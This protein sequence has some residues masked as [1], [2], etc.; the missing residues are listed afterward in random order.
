MAAIGE[1]RRASLDLA[2]TASSSQRSGASAV[3]TNRQFAA[4][5]RDARNGGLSGLSADEAGTAGS[6]NTADL[7]E[8]FK[9][10]H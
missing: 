1:T 10:P 8:W 5:Q 6:D 7:A 2:Q 3:G 4:T 9:R